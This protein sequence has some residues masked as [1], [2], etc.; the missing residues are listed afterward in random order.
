MRL[1]KFL[2]PFAHQE[3]GSGYTITNLISDFVQNFI[4]DRTDFTHNMTV[5]MQHESSLSFWTELNHLIR[6]G[7]FYPIEIAGR[8]IRNALQIVIGLLT[9]PFMLGTPY[10]MTA[11]EYLALNSVETILHAI[12]L[13][14]CPVDFIARLVIRL[15][16]KIGVS[17]RAII[18]TS[19]DEL[20]S[21]QTLQTTTLTNVDKGHTH[22]TAELNHPPTGTSLHRGSTYE[23]P[24]PT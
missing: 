1:L 21:T 15:P 8:L 4:R 23:P 11:C 22:K 18:V 10:F 6:S 16:A 20:Y 17:L 13:V 24:N 2:K 5:P 7:T 9:L 12:T 14:S 19:N 3:Q